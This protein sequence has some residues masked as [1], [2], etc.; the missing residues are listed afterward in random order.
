[1]KVLILYRP[2]SEFARPIE[3]FVREF[4]H[5]HPGIKIE[6]VSVD[7]R[8]GSA[9]STLYDILDHPAIM[10]MRDDGS[11]VQLWQGKQLPLMDGVAAYA[12]G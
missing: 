1:M 10:V 7:T 5:R 2:N 12:R 9:T 8:E 3:E 6:T 11:V 4:E